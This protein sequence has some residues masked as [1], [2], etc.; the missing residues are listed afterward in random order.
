M[1]PG[2]QWWVRGDEW[3]NLQELRGGVKASGLGNPSEMGGE[4]W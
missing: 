3:V 4:R 2:G 1:D